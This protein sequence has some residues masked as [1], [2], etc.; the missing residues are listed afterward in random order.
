MEILKDLLAAR[1]AARQI[2]RCN[3]GMDHWPL[4][5][6]Q[7]TPSRVVAMCHC[8]PYRSD[9]DGGTTAGIGLRLAVELLRDPQGSVVGHVEVWRRVA[10]QRER[11]TPDR[12]RQFSS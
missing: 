7:S 8:V 1:T 5:V 10:L 4:I 11:G 12:G 2:K 9:G 3:H 6:G